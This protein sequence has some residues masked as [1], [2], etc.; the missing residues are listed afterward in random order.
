[1]RRDA[2]LVWQYV[3]L[4]EENFQLVQAHY[5]GHWSFTDDEDAGAE[6]F[7]HHATDVISDIE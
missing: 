7:D 4:S 2:E 3:E 1:M 6:P 5:F